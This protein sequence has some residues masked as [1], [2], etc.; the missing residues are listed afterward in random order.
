MFFVLFSAHAG[1]F[2][3]ESGLNNNQTEINKLKKIKYYKLF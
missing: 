2:V 3:S 1:I